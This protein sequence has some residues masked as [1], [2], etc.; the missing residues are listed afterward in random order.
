LTLF[1]DDDYVVDLT[2]GS[3]FEQLI[4][5]RLRIKKELDSGPANDEFLDSL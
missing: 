1:G 5:F 2:R 4:D 3:F